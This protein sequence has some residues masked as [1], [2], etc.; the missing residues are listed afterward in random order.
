M[1][2]EFLF[3]FLSPW[4][5]ILISTHRYMSLSYFTWGFSLPT[6]LLFCF[7]IYFIFSTIVLIYMAYI[8]LLFLFIL[9]FCPLL[10]PLIFEFSYTFL[11]TEKS[12]HC[13]Y[14]NNIPSLPFCSLDIPLFLSLAVILTHSL[15]RFIFFPITSLIA[16]ILPSLYYTLLLL[17]PELI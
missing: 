12:L 4:L 9:F 14:H 17:S 2:Y 1:L 15:T 13:G 3:Y 11:H 5:L 10:F 8:S 16:N 7:C 6:F